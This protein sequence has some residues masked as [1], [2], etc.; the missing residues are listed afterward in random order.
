MSQ[1]QP[2]VIEKQTFDDLLAN[3]LQAVTF[4]PGTYH[5]FF[6]AATT[7]YVRGNAVD[8]WIALAKSIA[9]ASFNLIKDDTLMTDR[10]IL[11]LA[12]KLSEYFNAEFHSSQSPS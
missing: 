3:T 5:L 6:G 7:S 4:N 8:D 11:S 2:V 9:N 12:L 1:Q 10:F